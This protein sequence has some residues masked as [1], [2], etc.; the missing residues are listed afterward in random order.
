MMD[1]ADVTHLLNQARVK[2][3]GAS[4]AG[5]KAE[6]YDTIYEFFKDSNSWLETLSI[7]VT[8][9]TQDYILVPSEGGQIIRLAGI[10]DPNLIPVAGFMPVVG[11]L[12][13]L[14]PVNTDQTYSVIVVKN[15]VPPTRSDDERTFKG[16]VPDAPDWLLHLY[17]SYIL[18]GIL[19]RMMLHANKSY[20][21]PTIATYHLRRYRDGIAQARVD[22]QRQN[23]IGAQAWNYPQQF[24]TGGQRGG[25]S[26]GNATS[27]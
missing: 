3:L 20:S 12:H 26:V 14:Y 6:L 21:N 11:T 10:F 23:T 1:K 5:L 15:I 2:L 16:T 22:A 13:L 7:G 4:E 27:F 19:G 25:V 8:D 17:Q 9:A 24:R 18:D